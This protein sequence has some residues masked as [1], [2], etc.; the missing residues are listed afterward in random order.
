MKCP[1]IKLCAAGPQF[2]VSLELSPGMTSVV[3]HSL[4]L[5]TVTV[6]FCDVNH[7]KLSGLKQ[8]DLFLVAPRWLL[9]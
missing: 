1:H 3:P 5:V 4:A 9:V 2:P 6:V 8:Q 7:C